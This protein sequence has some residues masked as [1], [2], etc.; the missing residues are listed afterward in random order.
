MPSGD[1]SG[2]AQGHFGRVYDYVIV[3]ACRAA[4]YWP[5]RMEAAASDKPFDIVKNVVDAEI[6]LC[7]LSASNADALYGLAVRHALDLPVVLAKDLKSFVM[8]NTGDFDA[9]EYDESLRIDTVQKAIEVLGEAVKKAV[10]NKK[11]RHPLLDRLSI[12]LS[13]SMPQN[14]TFEP[15]VEAPAPEPVKESKEPKLPIISPLPDYVGDPFTEEQMAKLK[16]GDSLFHLNHGKGKVDFV[17]NMGKDRM[18]SIKFDSGTKL[19]VLV[20]SD[21]FR[22][23]EK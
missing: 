5:A 2:Y 23:I 4:G 18:A 7:D 15:T 11:D 20:V 8:F 12:G 16:G 17:K 9:V 10:E 21:F 1:P 14:I 6:I 22:R 19:L 3:P 13:Q